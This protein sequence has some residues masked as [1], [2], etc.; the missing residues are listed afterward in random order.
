MVVVVQSGLMGFDCLKASNEFLAQILELSDSLMK[1]SAIILFAFAIGLEAQTPVPAVQPDLLN[2]D[3]STSA[4]APPASV[5]APAPATPAS[6]QTALPEQKLGPGDQVSVSVSDCPDLT[7]NFRVSADGT[8]PLPLLHERIQAAG[9]DPQE[10]ETDIT[11]ALM[12]EEVLVRPVVSVAVVEYRSIPVSVVGAVRQPITFQAVGNV[13]LL[14]ALARAGGLSA[15]AGSEIIVSKP[16][17]LGSTQPALLQRVPVKALFNEADPG[18]NLRLMGG[19]EIRVPTAG[20][21]YVVGNVKRSG[22]FSIQE[23]NGSSVL[24]AIALTEGLMPYTN[25]QAF[26][27]RR[28]AWQEP[29]ERDSNRIVKDHR[30]QESRRPLVG[31][32][33]SLHTGQQ[34]P[35]DDCRDYRTGNRIRQRYRHRASGLALRNKHVE[36]MSGF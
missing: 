4:P 7:R 1:L 16:Q 23:A 18:L 31:R 5:S 14:D 13:T 15:E 33:H 21:F 8:L 34:G 12:R 20:K 28:E 29:D 10:I 9:R 26:I 22:A 17:P 32:R 25:K 35:E 27:Y 24:K 11:N 19:E 6:I 2:G 3:T 36:E 30:S